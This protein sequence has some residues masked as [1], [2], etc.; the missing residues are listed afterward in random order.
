MATANAA[1]HTRDKILSEIVSFFAEYKFL[2]LL[3]IAGFLVRV[4]AATH[5]Q[6]F[7]IDMNDWIAW[8]ERMRSVG[9]R[10]FYS[11]GIFADYAP[12]YIYVF[13]LSA[14]AKHAFFESSS[15]ETYYFLHRLPPILFD[16]GIAALIYIT[17]DQ[18]RKH[19]LAQPV[20][21]A[22]T[23]KGKKKAKAQPRGRDYGRLVPIIAASCFLFSPVTWFNSAAWGQ[24]DSSFTFFMVL[25]VVFLLRDRPMLAVIA[26]V[27]GFFLKPQAVTLAPLL[28]VYLLMRYTPIDW[29]K[30]AAAGIVTAFIVIFPF[31]GFASFIRLVGVLSKSVEVYPYTS[32]YMYNVWGVFYRFWT[33]DTTTIIAGMPARRIGTL[34]F[35]IGV[36]IG[37][38][39]MIREMRKTTDEPKTLY[40]FAT[41]FTF[42][43]VMVLTRMHERYIFPALPFLLGF[44]FLYQ[45]GR[46][47]KEK[48]AAYFLNLPFALYVAVTVLHW[49][50]LY[51]V[52]HYYVALLKKT[53]VDQSNIF[54]YFVERWPHLWSLLMLVTFLIFTLSIFKWPIPKKAH[55]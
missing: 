52:Y 48:L 12:G 43:P 25:S 34:L 51:Y 5:W 41:Y 37:V 23:K 20:A 8:G 44:A 45:I 55:G 9:P 6:P 10:A 13:G 26:Y 30:F 22:K 24:L 53:S 32:M 31:F 28:A 49:F 17:V 3:L 46:Q 7:P 2:M 16:L 29:A 39:L 14:W 47:R 36:A 18:A 33:N 15:Q 50:A 1:L 21:T 54:F 19:K 11:G 27:L 40:F 38:V 4:W 42:M 35:L